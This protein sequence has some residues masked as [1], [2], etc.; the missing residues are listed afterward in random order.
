MS[1]NER[2]YRDIKLQAC[3]N[4]KFVSPPFWDEGPYG[5]TFE[6]VED[7]SNETDILPE[8]YCY[9]SIYI[10]APSILDSY[11]YITIVS[12]EVDPYFVCDNYKNEKEIE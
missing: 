12:E 2:N 6:S 11:K 5:C 7:T 3:I 10:P 8:G 9:Q 1:L 4:C